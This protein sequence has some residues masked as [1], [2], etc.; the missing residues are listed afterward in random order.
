MFIC[1]KCGTVVLAG[2]RANRVVVEWRERNY[3]D[4][5]DLALEQRDII[6]IGKG[7]KISNPFKALPTNKKP[8]K[9]IVKEI[10]VCDSCK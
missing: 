7:V 5:S 2:T 3:F 1:G 4:E 6:N 8:G 9:E 10:L